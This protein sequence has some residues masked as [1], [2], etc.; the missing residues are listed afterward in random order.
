M[1][2][3]AGLVYDNAMRA[4]LTAMLATALIAAAQP[5]DRARERELMTLGAANMA[6]VAGMRRID[7]AVLAAMR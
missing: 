6:E 7:P 1:T 3:A 5:G 4:L 2:A